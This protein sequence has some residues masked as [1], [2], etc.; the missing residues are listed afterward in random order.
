MSEINNV[1][2]EN[3][4][5]VKERA[6]EMT[7]PVNEQDKKS[8]KVVIFIG[9]FLIVLAIGTL[10][11]FLL[12]ANMRSYNLA[13]EYFESN[14]YTAARE[15]FLELDEYRDST[16]MVKWCDF[17]IGMLLYN[18]SNFEEASIVFY[19]LVDFE[20]SREM[21]QRCRFELAMILFIEGN[22]VEAA[23]AFERLG[24]FENANDMRMLCEYNIALQYYTSENFQEASVLFAYLG[25]FEDS[26]EMAKRSRYILAL[27]LFDEGRYNDALEM[28]TSLGDFRNSSV[29]A[30]VCHA[31][32]SI[33]GQ[34]MHALSRGLMA[35][36]EQANADIAAMSPQTANVLNR[37]IDLE[38]EQI[39][40]FYEMI[41]E[42]ESLQEDAREYIS[43]LR[44][45]RESTVD[46][47]LTSQT[48]MDTWEGYFNQR[49][50][51]ISRFVGEHGL[52]V[53]NEF[54]I[55]LD[56][57]MDSPEEASRRAS[58]RTSVR[59]MV[60]R[61]TAESVPQEIGFNTHLITMSNTTDRAFERFVVRVT[62]LDDNDQIVRIAWSM[63]VE[64]W[65]PGEE[66][67]V[68]FWT[69][70]NINVSDYNLEFSAS[71]IT[72]IFFE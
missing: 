58:I 38:L 8:K 11:A 28:F 4:E 44:A 48:F 71:Y 23:S 69:S 53:D 64:D 62:F 39:E 54:Q 30:Q 18:D 59:S 65:E 72:G 2:E 31:V 6:V 50:T 57:F 67:V 26:E 37:Y 19:Q 61:F 24:D 9:S 16:V 43:I 70:E 1:K 29:L 5:V 34:F 68:E 49:G 27:S 14:N 36:W 45:S 52:T 7:K 42:N 40:V 13:M 17:N 12:T 60:S 51:L 46:F 33:D 3:V 55:H 47:N 21:Y 32:E 20:N 56:D 63:P 35:R 10:C 66:I 41:F 15:I 25:N 22:Y